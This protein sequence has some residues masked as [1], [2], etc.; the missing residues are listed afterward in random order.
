MIAVLLMALGVGGVVASTQVSAFGWQG[1]GNLVTRLAEK[2]GKSEEEVQAVFDEMR[3]EHQ[4]Q[5]QAG[6]ES[7]L[8][9]AVANGEITSEQKQMILAKHEELRAEREANWQNKEQM[10]REE[11]RVQRQEKQAGLEAWAAENGIEME[12][13]WGKGAG[14]A[15]LGVRGKHGGLGAN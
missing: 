13:I 8:D 12:N 14:M 15:G 6:F 1:K 10:T 3:E 5:M 7:R 4:T 11:W 2:L 9:E